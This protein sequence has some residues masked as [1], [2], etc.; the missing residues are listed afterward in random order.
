M[1]AKVI[2]I[3]LVVALAQFLIF[4]MLTHLGIVLVGACGWGMW[5][6]WKGRGDA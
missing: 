4:W 6:W 3:L 5:S 2:W 1:L